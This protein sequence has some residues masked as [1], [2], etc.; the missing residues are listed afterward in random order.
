MW[1]GEPV[2]V[3]Q[4]RPLAGFAL[5]AVLCA[6]LMT[7]SVSRGWS[8]DLIHPGRPIVTAGQAEKAPHDRRAAEPTADVTTVSIPVELSAQPLG[9]ASGAVAG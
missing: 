1:E 8:L 4:K 2:G 7:L 3:D 5:V 9:A 6:V